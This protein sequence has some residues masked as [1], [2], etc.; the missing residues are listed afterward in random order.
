[1]NDN[2][3]LLIVSNDSVVYREGSGPQTVVEQSGFS[4]VDVDVVFPMEMAEVV[5]SGVVDAGAET[6]GYDSALIPQ[7]VAVN[8]TT[9]G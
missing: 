2:S 7:G 9:V 4:L 3:P 6:L 1:M 8:R 5:L